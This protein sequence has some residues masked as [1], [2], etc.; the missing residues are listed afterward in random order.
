MLAV[1]SQGWEQPSG[2]SMGPYGT[3]HGNKKWGSWDVGL[4]SQ[5]PQRHNM[6]RFYKY[7]IDR[8]TPWAPS[9]NKGPLCVFPLDWFSGVRETHA[10]IWRVFNI[11]LFGRG[12]TFLTDPQLQEE[13]DLVDVTICPDQES[14]REEA[15]RSRVAH[16]SVQIWCSQRRS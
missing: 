11:I 15:K 14:E 3:W 1:N 12:D 2:E 13:V 4:S 16:Q 6:V 10:F 5:G 9:V 8:I 7:D